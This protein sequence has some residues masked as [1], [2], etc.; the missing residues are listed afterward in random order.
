MAVGGELVTR[1]DPSPDRLDGQKLSARRL[2]EQG[3]D[4]LDLAGR[5]DDVIACS[6][7]AREPSGG[8]G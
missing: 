4:P 7:F 8:G 1:V 3:L 6:V 5:E 2:L